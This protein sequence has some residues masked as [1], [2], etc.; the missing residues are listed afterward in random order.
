MSLW[1]SLAENVVSRLISR[2]RLSSSR[3][4]LFVLC[5]QMNS[6]CLGLSRDKI[7]LLSATFLDCLFTIWTTHWYEEMA[8]SVVRRGV[9]SKSVE[10]TCMNLSKLL[11]W[12]CI[13]SW[14]K[15]FRV[16]KRVLRGFNRKGKVRLL[17]LYYP[18]VGVGIVV[19]Y[20]FLLFL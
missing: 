15:S 14:R 3:V 13:T 6:V 20:I 18:L 11:Q 2:N 19:S 4:N 10:P 8:A 17:A 5:F 12:G 1:V 7:C 9:S 16:V